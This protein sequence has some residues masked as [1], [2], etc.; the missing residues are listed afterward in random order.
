[1]VPLYSD[2]FSLIVLFY[3]VTINTRLFTS[4][5]LREA[6]V[7]HNIETLLPLTPSEIGE[8]KEGKRRYADPTYTYYS[9]G[10]G[11]SKQ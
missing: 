9:A 1:M 11:A 5:N 6:G 7:L 10:C 4:A 8:W 3:I 2:K